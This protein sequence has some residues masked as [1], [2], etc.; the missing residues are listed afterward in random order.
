MSGV[1]SSS[2]AWSMCEMCPTSVDIPVDV[3]TNVPAP[4]VT[5]VFM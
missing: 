4:R 1:S 3:T 2:V 5:F